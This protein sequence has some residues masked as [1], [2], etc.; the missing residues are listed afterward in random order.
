MLH[1]IRIKTDIKQMDNPPARPTPEPPSIPGVLPDR[2]GEVMN[3][4]QERLPE[5]AEPI[6]EIAEHEDVN[7]NIIP[8]HTRGLYR[9]AETD[10]KAEIIDKLE[11]K[12]LDIEWYRI[13]YHSCGHD[14]NNS[15]CGNW[16]S[17]IEQGNIPDNV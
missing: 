16:Q 3:D 4:L 13:E 6:H 10:N 15:P 2:V 9:F 11:K 12:L 8:A 5:Q 7:G 1:A 14:G 17:E